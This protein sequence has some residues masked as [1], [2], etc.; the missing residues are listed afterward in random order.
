MRRRNVSTTSSAASATDTASATAGSATATLTAPTTRMSST[1]VSVYLIGWTF[2]SLLHILFRSKNCLIVLSILPSEYLTDI[3]LI[4]QLRRRQSVRQA[5]GDAIVHSVFRRLGGATDHTTARTDQTSP[6]VQRRTVLRR[7]FA[8]TES[9]TV[10]RAT[11][12]ST[13]L[14]SATWT[15]T[16]PTSLTRPIVSHPISLTF[17]LLLLLLQVNLFICNDTCIYKTFLDQSGDGVLI[18]DR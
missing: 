11:N 14:G 2:A 18:S 17:F 13:R 4:L 7:T 5:S 6:D 3:L 1:A 16:V 8:T 15:A 9:S 12:A 10:G